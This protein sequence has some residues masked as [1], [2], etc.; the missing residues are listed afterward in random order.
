MGPTWPILAC[1]WFSGSILCL[2]LAHVT[3]CRCC[4]QHSIVDPGFRA[5]AVATGSCVGLVGLRGFSS[6][7]LNYVR[8]MFSLLWWWAYVGPA[9]DLW[10]A[11]VGSMSGP[12]EAMVR[13]DGPKPW[14]FL[15]SI[16]TRK[17]MPVCS[18]VGSRCNRGTGFN[19][20]LLPKHHKLAGP[21]IGFN[22]I[23]IS[24]FRSAVVESV[25]ELL[26][27]SPCPPRNRWVHSKGITH[28]TTARLGR[29]NLL[30][31]AHGH[32]ANGGNSQCWRFL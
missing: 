21:T 32:A 1:I 25:Q 23:V 5:C 24:A 30:H 27:C 20:G 26:F 3:G 29:Q 2:F 31:F 13:K 19:L 6:L 4:V 8:P 14:P 17:A 7:P 16:P 9:L 10:W 11:C 18:I 15:K 28:Q 12:F 22:N